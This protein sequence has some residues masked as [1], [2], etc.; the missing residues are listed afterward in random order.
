MNLKKQILSFYRASLPIFTSIT[1]P[2]TSRGT[3]SADRYQTITTARFFFDDKNKET[4]Y[5]E[6]RNGFI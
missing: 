3:K 6:L 1:Q 2:N 4:S 5:V